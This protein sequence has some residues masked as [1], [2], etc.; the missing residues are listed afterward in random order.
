[1]GVELNQSPRDLRASSHS[2]N[3]STLSN[4]KMCQKD[5]IRIPSRHDPMMD[6][7]SRTL[8]T[9]PSTHHQS[10]RFSNHS[11]G[12]ESLFNCKQQTLPTFMPMASGGSNLSNQYSKPIIPNGINRRPSSK[13]SSRDEHNKSDGYFTDSISKHELPKTREMINNLLKY[14]NSLV[15]Q[16]F[17]SK[18]TNV[19]YNS[20]SAKV[21][22]L[23]YNSSNTSTEK[24]KYYQQ[25]IKNLEH[26][27]NYDD[28]K[29]TVADYN[30][31]LTR[32]FPINELPLVSTSSCSNSHDIQTN[33][34]MHLMDTFKL[35]TNDIRN[36]KDL[37]GGDKINLNPIN[38]LQTAATNLQASKSCNQHRTVTSTPSTDMK[39]QR[40]LYFA[41]TKSTNLFG[42]GDDKGRQLDGSLLK[43]KLTRSIHTLT[44]GSKGSNKNEVKRSS[45]VQPIDDIQLDRRYLSGIPVTNT[46]RPSSRPLG[47]NRHNST[48]SSTPNSSRTT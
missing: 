30:H 34:F 15:N 41:V 11:R 10:E 7:T 14:K 37:C 27:F 46:V 12:N 19:S 48:Q 9:R 32:K 40:P 28:I 36:P 38:N 33:R 20:D 45:T 43:K 18:D 24:T 42:S 23:K 8:N 21:T 44:G 31:N 17:N 2:R 6:F 5:S 29:R 22:S 26:R 3:N 4:P 1:M 13:L 39:K 47:L 35:Q 25:N 16:S